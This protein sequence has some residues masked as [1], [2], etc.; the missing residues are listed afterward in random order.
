[1]ALKNIK[2]ITIEI[3]GKTDQLDKA[4]KGVNRQIKD[5]Q[6][7]LRSVE[8][9]LKLDPGNVKL[10]EQKQNELKS[11]VSKTKEKLD[12]EKKALEDLKKNNATGEVTEKQ[13]ALEDEIAR[14]ETQLKSL[15][16]EYETF[17]SVSNQQIQQA[18]EKVGATGEKMQEVGKG[19]TTYVTAPIVAGFTAAVKTT[20]DFDSQMSKVQAISGATGKDF[21]SLRNKAR[22]MGAKT[23]FSATESG[24]AMEYMA[25]A[26]WKTNDMLE[27]ID[28]V[29]NLAAASGEDLGKTSDIVTDALTAFGMEAKEAGRFSDVLAATSTNANTNV[30]MLGETFKY[31]APVAGA[32]G[33]SVADV[34][35]AAGLMANSGIKASQ[36]GTTLRSIFTRMAK[37]TKESATAMED[38]GISLDDG[39]GNMKSFREVMVDMRKSF[40]KLKIPAEDFQKQMAQLDQDLEDGTIT[41]K[42]YNASVEDL[43]RKAYGAEGAEKARAA[44]MLAGQRGMSGLLAIVNA[45]DDDFDKLTK[46]VD[47]SGGSAQRMAETMQDNLSGQLTILMSQLQELAISFGDIMM[48][49]IRDFVTGIQGIVDKFNG[50]DEGT[51]KAIVKF[52]LV[53]AAIG[54]VITAIGGLLSTAATLTLAIT[55]AGGLAAAGTVLTGAM[56]AIATA[57]A[58]FLIGGAIV[59]GVIAGGVAIYKNWDK[60]KDGAKKLKDSLGEAFKNIGKKFG[61]M[62][63]EAAKHVDNIKTAVANKFTE[64][65]N[66]A[67]TLAGDIATTVGTKFNDAKTKVETIAGNIASTVQT[68][69]NDAKTKAG[70]AFDSI[71]TTISTKFTESKNKVKEI[72]GNISSAIHDKFSDAKKKAENAFSNIGKTISGKLS[73]AKTNVETAVSNIT[74]AMRTKFSAA[75][76]AA[77]TAFDSIKS[78]MTSKMS[79]AK[80]TVSTV[81]G[82]ISSGFSRIQSTISGAGTKFS[83]FVS[84]LKSFKF[85]FPEIKMPHF[86][87]TTKSKK[88]LGKTFTYPTGFDVEWYRRAYSNPVMFTRPTVLQ[89]PAG[90]KGFGDGG[91]AEIVLS[92]Q[93]LRQ[94]AGGGS[95]YNFNIYAAAG[96]NINQIA[97][98][99]Q[100]R[101]VAI[102]QQK[103]ASGWA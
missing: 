75:K 67:A 46:A 36:A 24:Q 64:A 43:T 26:G 80:T 57:A 16:K 20:A 88:I 37:P 21:D 63:D 3:G 32:L 79:A 60:I 78:A 41:E 9:L 76:T 42:Q 18:A 92:D 22:E 17:G 38:L 12:L 11:A 4:L 54:P 100:R 7:E 102:E 47:N 70:A 96:Q 97:D 95:T 13:K 25:M 85:K 69:F 65:K 99:V 15:T 48:P 94:I 31:A 28:G 2:G 27:G 84:A 5:T 49:A 103:E 66:K 53:A 19:M 74:S 40:G 98:E 33:Y 34:S 93:K 82:G 68:K 91:G 50:L 14:T 55:G 59:A 83:S 81:I 6:T 77:S 73:S 39:K 56:G 62:K 44:A 86:T 45:S 58:P 87:L 35:V 23:K 71:K 89:T 29:M 72:A 8:K 1:M 51:K 10:L 52:G 61:E 30:S 101:L 90:A